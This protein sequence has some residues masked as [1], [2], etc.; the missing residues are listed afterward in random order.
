MDID[1]DFPSDFNPN[2]VFPQ[3]VSA[4]MIKKGELGKHP[5]GQYFQSIP[6][7]S[8]TELSA[9]PYQQAEEL[10]FIKIDFLHLSLLDQIK[11]KQE[12][13]ELIDTEPN[14]DL[15]L[16]EEHVIK[17]FHINKHYELL[18]K[19]Q[20]SSIEELADC[21]ALIRPGKR[22]LVDEYIKHPQKVRK[23]LYTQDG[24]EYTFKRGH[25]IA[26]A[27]NIIAQLNL[28]ALKRL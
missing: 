4:S 12:L 24:G 23:E 21:L 19:I 26:Y 15:L 28:I 17:L 7:D 3:S 5:C 9:I 14:W 10:G 6:R 8:I 20:P 27:L 22:Q 1:L 11:S 2:V 25:A 13:R 16:D 18:A